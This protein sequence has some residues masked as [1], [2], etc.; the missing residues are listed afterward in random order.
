MYYYNQN[1]GKCL[2]FI[3]GGCGGNQNRFET[4]KK[5]EKTCAGNDVV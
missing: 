4:L 1:E 3:Y 2:Q 5:C